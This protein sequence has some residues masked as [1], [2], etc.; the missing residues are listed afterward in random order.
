MTAIGALE[1][2]RSRSVTSQG[3]L[4]PYLVFLIL[5][6]A[7]I[8][9][10]SKT[11][12][13]GGADPVVVAKAVL[14]LL[15]LGLAC[16]L[17]VTRSRHAVRCGPVVFLLAYL[18]CTVLGG[19]GAASLWPSAVVAVRLALLAA[20]IVVLAV[21]FRAEPLLG[22]LVAALATYGAIAA[23]TGLVALDGGRLRGAFPPLHPNE[24]A[25]M[26]SLVVLWCAWKAVTGRDRSIHLLGVAL[27]I[28]V[29]LATGSRTPLA[30]MPLGALVLLVHASALRRRTVALGVIAAPVLLWLVAGTSEFRDLVL[31]SGDARG[32]T[33]L[34]NRTIAWQAALAPKE[35]LWLEWLG[36]GL[37]L[38]R[39]EVSG[40]WWDEQI[41]DSSWISALV[42]GGVIGLGLCV[43]WLF[44]SLVST[45]DSP[46][47]ERALSLAL[48][49]YLASRGL[50]ES[51]LFD[52]SPAFLVLM[53]VVA[54]IPVREADQPLVAEPMLEQDEIGMPGG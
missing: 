32:L 41:L 19:W 24:L 13:Q 31:R 43:L 22:A 28:A 37:V 44:Y 7:T 50:L 47:A 30:A 20:T 5:I 52:A 54:T 27:G 17:C 48:L 35:S 21:C 51:G 12:Y 25:S 1:P 14:S 36:G 42:Q 49:V 40:Q 6:A 45:L 15:A 26:A 18:A 39:I 33:T 2:P 16:L 46:P 4:G 34:S 11:Y 8:P 10:R 53:T 3:R 29:L 9:W 23:V 38:K